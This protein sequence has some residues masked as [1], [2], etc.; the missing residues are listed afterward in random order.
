MIAGLHG[1]FP[2]LVTPL[3]EE[4]FV[5]PAALAGL[6]EHVYQNGADGVYLCGSTGEGMA[7][8]GSERRKVAEVAVECSPKGKSVIVHVGARSQ[9]EA[10]ELAKH[11]GALGVA[12][13][14]SLPPAGAAYQEIINYYRDLAAASDVPVLAYY[15][16]AATG[17][18]WT[19]GQLEEI[20]GIPGV[21]G[22]KFTD[23]DLY[24]MSLLARSGHTVFNGRDEVL[25]A[26]LLMGAAGGIGSIYNIVPQWFVRVAELARIGDWKQARRVQ[27]QIND[28]IRVLLR[29]PL[30]PAIKRVLSWRGIECGEAVKPRRPLTETEEREL[31]SAFDR[32]EVAATFP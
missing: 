12:A 9:R 26:G 1:I 23:F 14:S 7:L 22:L 10:I 24:T 18:A 2:A 15:F 31:R 20:C 8:P 13:I 32:M 5:N 3:T 16:P 17:A 28:L 4:E 19:Y 11:A 27:D 21:S 30:V 6:L 25:C 29:Y